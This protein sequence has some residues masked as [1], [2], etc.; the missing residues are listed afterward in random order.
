M[1]PNTLA[2]TTAVLEEVPPVIVSP[3]VNSPCTFDTTTFPVAIEPPVPA[4]VCA[5]PSTPVPELSTNSKSLFA[6]PPIFCL[7]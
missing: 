1:L 5:E 2:F 6:V 4:P 3:A 7:T